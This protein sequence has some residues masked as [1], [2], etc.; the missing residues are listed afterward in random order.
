MGLEKAHAA[1]LGANGQTS[2]E[3]LA[4]RRDATSL[5]TADVI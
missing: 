2:F 1:E 4:T 3:T 5:F